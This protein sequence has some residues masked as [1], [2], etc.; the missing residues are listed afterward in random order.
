MGTIRSVSSVNARK[1]KT[2]FD[3]DLAYIVSGSEITMGKYF[4]GL[5]Y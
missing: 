1:K 3:T 2:S 5:T 4:L